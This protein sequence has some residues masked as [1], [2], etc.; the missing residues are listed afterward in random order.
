MLLEEALTARRILQLFQKTPP[1]DLATQ[2][3]MNPTASMIEMSGSD[4]PGFQRCGCCGQPGRKTTGCSCRGGKSHTCRRLLLAGRQPT[5]GSDPSA[6]AL[7]SQA[8]GGTSAHYAGPPPPEP[9]TQVSAPL[10]AA[11]PA[12][13]VPA[14]GGAQRPGPPEEAA[15]KTKTAPPL[16]AAGRTQPTPNCYCGRLASKDP[17][18]KNW[19]C[20][21]YG[22][23]RGQSCVFN[24]AS[25]RRGSPRGELR[26][27]ALSRWR[28]ITK[29]I[30]SILRMPPEEWE[31]LQEAAMLDAVNDDDLA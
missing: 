9:A 12:P 2:R 4:A 28:R 25:P 7:E 17:E 15:G 5:R 10:A 8:R 13:A 31:I 22:N 29:L 27:A 19:Q 24:F 1:R 14:A 26:L 21:N 20:A 11:L 30:I 3:A 16:E 6:P 23:P 18:S